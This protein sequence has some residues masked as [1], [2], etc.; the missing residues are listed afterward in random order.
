MTAAWQAQDT[1]SD[2]GP[3]CPH[4]GVQ[5]TADEPHY[6]DEMG[7]TEDDCGYCGKPFKVTVYHSTT[8]SCEPA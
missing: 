1:Y 2:V 5:F 8:W 4:C 7:Y 3:Q 6:Y